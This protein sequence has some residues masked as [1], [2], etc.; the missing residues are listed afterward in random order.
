MISRFFRLAMVMLIGAGAAAC[1]TTEATVPVTYK[2][3][4]GSTAPV[5]GADAVTVNVQGVDGRVANRAVISR[6]VN[7]YNMDMA[8][9]RSSGNVVDLVARA[10]RQELD[11][12]GFQAFVN[13]EQSS[14]TIKVELLE[15]YNDYNA[16]LVSMTR[17]ANVRFVV[18]VLDSQGTSLFEE[19][20]HGRH[21]DEVFVAGA[22]NAKEGVE[23]A[24]TN[25]M[26]KLVSN[27]S[28][29][30]ALVGPDRPTGPAPVPTS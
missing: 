3:V 6:K 18:Q 19:T 1:A 2:P 5:N 8:S 12:R 11:N 21:A 4:P 14:R 13:G 28:F 20:V 17:N 29:F 30:D 16:G 27:R 9:I 24:L 15:F 7:G 10:L 26:S 25:A 22:D 23:L